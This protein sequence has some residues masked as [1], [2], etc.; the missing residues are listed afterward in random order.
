[1]V[2][3]RGM[4]KQPSGTKKRRRFPRLSFWRRSKDKKSQSRQT[5][6]RERQASV[7]ISP[8][9][10]SKSGQEEVL[11]DSSASEARQE[12]ICPI[13]F[14][15]KL[16]DDMT[17]A[18][19]CNHTA[20]YDCLSRYMIQE[21]SEGRVNV[22][23][24]QCSTLFLTHEIRQVLQQRHNATQVEYF[25]M[26]YGEFTLR[27]AL[28]QE[29]DLRYCPAPDC[30][31][32]VI[33]SNCA[34]C[35]RLVCQRPE[36]G[37]SFCYHCQQRWHPSMTCDESR[38][39]RIR[40]LADGSSNELSE[41]GGRTEAMASQEEIKPCPRCK[42]LVSKVQDGSCNHMTCFV[43]GVDFCWLCMREITDLH[44][45]SPS[46]C[47]FWGKKPWSRRKRIIWQ[48]GTLLAAPFGIALLAAVAAP[49]LIVGIP[50]Y[51]GHR[52]SVT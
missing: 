11:E 49:A 8:T 14:E 17:G 27:R 18:T 16:K 3:S 6:D 21:V 45:L 5:E 1:V 7:V 12:H 43:C 32:A 31:Y 15:S 24:P 46:G 48:M 33:A 26:K 22:S 41:L 23:C 44:Y 34:G 25:M 2:D 9:E 42:T 39:L 37:T 4:T 52:V 28:A 38:R 29:T 30:S 13:C 10:N 35:P 50:A 51:V 19:D 20:C 47:T 36:C 40:N